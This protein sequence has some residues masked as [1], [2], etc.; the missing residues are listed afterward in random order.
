MKLKTIALFSLVLI[1][2]TAAFA[3]TNTTAKPHPALK[4]AADKSTQTA[5]LPT[6]KQVLDKYAAAVGGRAANEKIKT[7]VTK[8]SFEF[9]PMGIKGTSE[10]YAAA[11]DK[12]YSKMNMQGIGEIIT[13]TD[14]KTAWSINP[15]QGSRDITGEE[16]LQLKLVNNL[17]REVNLEKLYANWTVKGVEKVG[18][19]D[20]YVLV[21]TPAGLAPE[22][23]Y[24]DS[25]SGLLVQSEGT[26]ISPE[27]KMPAKSFYEDYRAI[28]GVKIPHK[29]R[30]VVPQAEII[31]TVTE[32]K[33]GTVI[34]EAKFAKPKQ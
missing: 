13:G 20:A 8:A 19:K 26:L 28:D 12:S 2:S 30:I 10:T 14:G 21:G 32:I 34:E 17:S 24:F 7:R 22:T 4:S 31:T 25:Q 15:I 11:P 9:A 23:F 5:K 29:M 6:A 16:L 33:H 3:Q 18:G 27:G 1:V